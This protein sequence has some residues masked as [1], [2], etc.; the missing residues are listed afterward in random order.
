MQVSA[1]RAAVC[2][3]VCELNL[4]SL[5]PRLQEAAQRLRLARQQ[6]VRMR[7]P[8]CRCRFCLLGLTHPMSDLSPVVPMQG[9]QRAL[10]AELEVWVVAHKA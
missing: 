10:D 7:H 6:E 5:M 9:R 1:I 4:F 2:D 3:G 8:I